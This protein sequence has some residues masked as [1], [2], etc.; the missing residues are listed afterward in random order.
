M[1]QDT[2]KKSLFAGLDTSL[3]HETSK[4][5][6]QETRLHE[7]KET[8]KLA[9][10]EPVKQVSQETSKRVLYPKVTYQLNP[11][12]TNMLQDTKLTLQR[13]YNVKVSLADI[14]EEAIQQACTDVHENKE[15]SFLVSKLTSKQ[16]SK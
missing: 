7:N 9:N 13:H 10:K 6:S 8:R 11:T 15:T 16:E 14:V 3:L 1:I 2:A 12:V 5:V 4:Q